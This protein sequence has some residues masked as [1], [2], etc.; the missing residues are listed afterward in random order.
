MQSINTG[1]TKYT[2]LLSKEPT[3][4]WVPTGID[5][6]LPEI[7]LLYLLT[8]LLVYQRMKLGQKVSIAIS[9]QKFEEKS[10]KL[11]PNS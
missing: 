3:P 11:V 9:K 5:L 7:H 4:E 1:K 6:F 10:E 8:Y 2:I